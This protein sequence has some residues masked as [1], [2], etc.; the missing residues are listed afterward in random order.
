MSD[1]KE[2]F[3]NVLIEAYHNIL[4]LEET[5]KKYSRTSFSFRDRNVIS[6]L[7]RFENGRNIG[8]VAAYLRISRPSATALI[9]KL[10]KHGLV[11]KHTEPG[12]ERG[13]MV[14]LT[15]KGQLFEIYQKRYRKRLA[16]KVGEEFTEEEKVILYRGFRKLSDFFEESINEMERLHNK[17]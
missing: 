5:K 3:N 17:K 11:E 10:E 8:D 14:A 9:K 1:F 12:N 15:K 13:T 7:V 6:Y 16:A 4:L 2:D